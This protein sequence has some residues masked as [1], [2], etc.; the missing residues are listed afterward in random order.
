MWED[1]VS[2]DDTIN[3]FV[4]NKS[5]NG[6]FWM[7]GVKAPGIYCLDLTA[8]DES[9]I[10]QNIVGDLMQEVFNRAKKNKKEGGSF[11]TLFIVDE[12]QNYADAG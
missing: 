7:I 12:A 2:L 4:A 6:K 11:K 3:G 8:V 10:R 1:A 9:S 5:E